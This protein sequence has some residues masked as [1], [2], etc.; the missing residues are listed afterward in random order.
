MYSIEE[1]VSTVTVSKLESNVFR[2]TPLRLQKMCPF[3]FY[4]VLANNVTR[5]VEFGKVSKLRSRHTI[6]VQYSRVSGFQLV[7][8]EGTNEGSRETGIITEDLKYH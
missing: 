7:F 4:K 3:F 5:L 1:A 8:R 6:L 2:N